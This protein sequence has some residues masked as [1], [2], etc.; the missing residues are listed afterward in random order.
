ME[1]DFWSTNSREKWP[2]GLLTT[3]DIAGFT[4]YYLNGAG[5]AKRLYPLPTTVGPLGGLA[6]LVE[7]AG[8]GSGAAAL[9]ADVLA[10]VAGE[11]LPSSGSEVEEAGL[12]SEGSV[13]LVAA[14]AGSSSG[15]PAGVT[16]SSGS[17]VWTVPSSGPGT[18]EGS[19]LLE[20]GSLV[21]L[22]SL[23]AL[24]VPLGA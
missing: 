18:T 5:G 7:A 21:D 2:D 23:E 6:G 12:A 1:A 14:E 17:V 19:V 9:E 13:L 22:L 8:A 3:N 4:Y 16:A 20:D 10:L 15:T 24:E 11:V